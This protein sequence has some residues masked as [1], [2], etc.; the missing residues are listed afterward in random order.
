[1]KA[2]FGELCLGWYRATRGP[3]LIALTLCAVL[4]LILLPGTSDEG[5]VHTGYG[6]G[7]YWAL[8]LFTSLW[9]GGT[10]YALDRERH[11]LALVFS[12]PIHRYKLWWGRWL[13]V[14]VPCCC[15]A[16]LGCL[17]VAFRALPE[18]RT[19]QSPRLPSLDQA[20]KTELARL[21]SLNRV[22]Q[23]IPEARLLRAVREDLET[24]YTELQPQTPIAY[25]FDLPADLP[26]DAT[27]SFR[28]SG[29][30]FLGAKDALRLAVT[31]SDAHG[32]SVTRTPE[33]L[34]DTGFTLSLPTSLLHAGAPLTITL[35]RLDQNEV[36]SVLF[37]PYSDLHLLLP[38]IAPLWNLVR[39]AV[40]MI[41]TLALTA[42][43][44]VALGCSFSLPVTL[45]TG[46]LAL[47]ACTISILSPSISAV[48]SVSSVWANISTII[49][50][51][52][53]NPF[54][55][56]TRHPPLH[57]LLAGEALSL[58]AIGLFTLRL[59]LPALVLCSGCAL[60]SSVKDEDR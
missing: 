42:A 45:F 7:L 3:L 40:V 36:A 43:L 11:R 19:V 51:T 47:L 38:G 4:C 21:R 14:W 57:A 13:A 24:R 5:L 58:R 10:A 54:I 8:L 27:A 16:L 15:A 59:V 25:T 28:L 41:L 17:M 9:C 12:K 55:D 34:L 2:L 23:N 20:A 26:T 39:F 29:A 49:S 53:A 22:P 32:V 46:V 30:P 18:G 50:E 35:T 44:G 6:L 48:D 33:R 56:L 37:Q 60:L 1:M 52:L 31:V